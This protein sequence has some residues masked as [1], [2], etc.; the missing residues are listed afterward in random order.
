[1]PGALDGLRILVPE[2]RELDLFVSMLEAEGAQALRCPLVRILDLEDTTAAEAWIAA[3]TAGEFQD[4]VWLT[5]EGVHRLLAVA[6]RKG[7]RAA[8]VRALGEVR[9]I[10]RGPKPARALRALG[11]APGLAAPVPTSQGVIDALAEEDIAGRAIALQLYPSGSELPL[12]AALRERGAVVF[13][14]T[15]YRYASHADASLVVDAIG[16]MSEGRIHMIAFTS[17]PQVDRLVE[18]ARETGLEQA[19]RRALAKMVVAAV[20]P[21]VEEQLHRHGVT[22]VLRPESSFHLKPFV[23]AIAASWNKR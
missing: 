4:V 9:S 2:T 16:E 13:P 15:P 11:H 6:E 14:V 1:M 5:G 12:L 21:V 7:D 10:T 18:V 19:L 20:G 22:R 23:R 8:F 3:L 17:S